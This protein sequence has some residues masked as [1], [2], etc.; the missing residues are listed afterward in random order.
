MPYT[1][2]KPPDQIKGLPKGGKAIWIAAFNA[3]IVEYKDDETK[4]SATAWAAVKTKY[5]QDKEGNWRAKQD[6]SLDRI[7]DLI[8]QALRERFGDSDDKPSP[9]VNEIYPAY[10]VYGLD[11]KY[12]RLSWSIMDG[13]VQLGADPVEVEQS[14]VEIRARQ[15]ESE[16]AIE[17]FMR[18]GQ[19]QDP[20][21]TAW[22]VTICEPGFTKNGWYHP[23]EAL[24]A[25]VDLFNGVD[26]NL[27]ELPTGATHV[28]DAL[29]DV[30]TLLVKNKVGWLDGCRHI[31]GEGLKATLHFL[32]SA[33]WLGRNIMQALKDGAQCYGLSYDAPVRAVKDV[34][35]GK[36]VFKLIKFLS[37]DSVDIVTRPAAGGRFNRAVASMPAQNKEAQMKKKLWDLV[38]EKRPEL[39]AGKEFEKI[40]DAEMD[41]LARM[42]MEPE[43]TDPVDPTKFAT[44][45]ELAIYRAGMSLERKLGES[46]LPELA[47]T[48]VR[49]Q[50]EG[51]AVQDAEIDTAVADEKDY[52]AK[53]ADS[54]RGGDA[55]PAGTIHGG[56]G[57]YD[58]ACMAMDRL[59]DL[60]KEDMERLAVMER[61]DGQLFFE[62]IRA[63][64][65]YQEF[66]KIPRFH[67]LREAYTFF[68]GDPEVSGVFNRKNL[69]A[70]LRG[71]QD[72]T[73]ATFTYVLGNT[74]GRRLVAAYQEQNF[75]EDLL[76]SIRKSV[77]D[78]R[79]Q[80]AVLVGGFPDLAT[81]DPETGDYQEIVGVTDEESTYTVGQKGNI[82][83]IT[84]KTII[85][86][87]ITIVQRLVTGLGRAARRTHAKYVWNKYIANANCSDGTAWFTAPHGNL[88]AAA[89]THATAL[90]AYKAIGKMTEKDSSER[91]GLLDSPD[92]KPNLIGP[93]DLM[94]TI[95]KIAA[96]DF[97]YTA[98]DLTTKVPNPLKGKVNSVVLSLL[99]D[100]NDWGLIL[101]ASLIDIVEMGYLN[102]RQEPELFLADS[103][104]SEQVF[105]ADKIR[106]KI[107]HEYAGAV[108][109]FRSGYKAVVA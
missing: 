57:S 20:E 41:T 6:L 91:I 31:A 99:A 70:E 87:D 8:Y 73:S 15:T 9:Y 103:P 17:M 33:K 102:G 34:V 93:I 64:Q 82:L 44:K 47:K 68:T 21:G 35:E 78:F 100:V 104:Q 76:I 75:R 10:L 77:K 83:T 92:A 1:T 4:A 42:A 14:W 61:L 79:Q 86:D 81:V 67:S 28:P 88:G 55:I 49:K 45:E 16:D 51:R 96:E 85:N 7:R 109:D 40:S 27:Y 32:D 90:I 23:D 66:D 30:K 26:V 98:N 59:F 29:F 24:R 53:M 108:I 11:A 48:R 36:S 105:V 69:P 19:A 25:A 56:L 89:L 50:F 5:E 97:Y 80:E 65:D 94:E 22:D 62:D 43:K 52:L 39:L 95:E 37:A 72:I 106:H 101:P 74:L 60:K 12:Y 71:R 2:D 54:N 38:Q 18:I 13:A 84:R 58:R 46:D 107:R 63:V 3:A